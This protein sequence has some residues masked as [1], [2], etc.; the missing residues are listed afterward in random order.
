MRRGDT[1]AEKVGKEE[2]NSGEVLGLTTWV[3]P[4][5][6]IKTGVGLVCS[7]AWGI[8]WVGFWI[9]IKHRVH[10]VKY[11]TRTIIAISPILRTEFVIF[12]HCFQGPKM[13]S[14]IIPRTIFAIFHF[15]KFPGT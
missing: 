10:L 5:V 11:S 7:W 8:G 15:S 14:T 2:M 6:Y 3:D 9:I 1:V 13:P 4:G 12:P